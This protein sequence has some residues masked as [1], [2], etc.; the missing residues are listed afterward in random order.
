MGIDLVRLGWPNAAVV[1]A[2]AMLPLFAL[3]FAP[4]GNAEAVAANAEV[5]TAQADTLN[6]ATTTNVCS[7]IE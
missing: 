3:A 5:V 4:T 7:A 2:F 6:V 1:L